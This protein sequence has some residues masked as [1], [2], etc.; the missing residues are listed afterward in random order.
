[1]RWLPFILSLCLSLGGQEPLRIGVDSWTT[2]NP[3]LLAQDTD[4]EAVD[5]VF[6]RLVTL[7]AQGEFIPE[8][9]ESWTVL[10]GGREVLLK[11][12]PGLTWQDGR[13]IEAE[14]LVFTWK[15]LR[16]PQVRRVGDTT[17]GVASLDSV[18]AE[19]P[20]QARIR[21]SRPRG[22]LL[23]D[24]Y[25]FIPVPR[26]LYQ[27][28]ADPTKSPVNFLPVGSGPYRVKELA[29]LKRVFL[30]RW[31][32]YHGVHPGTW[33]SIELKD[34][35]SET[36]I[37]SA[38]EAGRVHFSLVGGLRYYLVR[39]GASG[40][41][42]VRSTSVPLASC[43]AFFLNCDP[44]RSLLGEVAVRRA[45]AELVPWEELARA[46]RFFPAR[47]ASSF[48]PPESWAHDPTSRPLPQPERAVAI[49]EQA[50]WRLGPDGIRVNAK[51]R[52]LE[53][54]AFESARTSVSNLRSLAAKALKVGFRIEVRQIAADDVFKK[55]SDH[56]GDL[57]SYGWS[58]ALDPDVDSPLFTQD[59]Y[60][61][62]A[63][64]M[65]YLNPE[66]ERL[67]Q[68]GRLTLEPKAR[69]RIYRH[70]SEIIYRDK[71]IIPLTYTLNRALFHRRLKGLAFNRLGQSYGFWPGR[72]GWKLED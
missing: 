63:N 71:P 25:N 7:N 69:Q 57:W 59:G 11:L 37:I 55:A 34:M 67:F 5:L 53:I 31:E 64:V 6:D 20:L 70:I 28:G 18:V 22:T 17:P 46:R 8:I 58:F 38:F 30:E 32:G 23:S 2:L 49:L 14:D 45:L 35:T 66:V 24:L 41:G 1:M 61:T 72:R 51:G 43:Q 42:V 48:W 36:R 62:H 47:L 50:G 4:A 15:M 56:E 60:R 52:R 16:L 21:L 3:L 12:R 27:V 29:T 9:L 26:H 44:G 68:E 54:V 19:G 13:P 40:A 65:G 10:S 39:K 33:P